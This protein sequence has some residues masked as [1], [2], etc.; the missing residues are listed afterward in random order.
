LP[1]AFSNRWTDAV[2]VLGGV[3]LSFAAIA[4]VALTPRDLTAPVAVVFAVGTSAAQAMTL[5]ADAGARV[6]RVGPS[7]NIVVVV[8]NDE[9]F[10]SR[11]YARGAL[12]VA[13]AST[14]E[15][16]EEPAAK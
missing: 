3:A 11:A 10:S 6:L 7:S 8:P 16:C 1:S 2:L 5:S 14:V 12:L 9:A 13:D 4:H 15:G